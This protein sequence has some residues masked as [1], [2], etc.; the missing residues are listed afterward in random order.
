MPITEEVGIAWTREHDH[1]KIP[2]LSSVPRIVFPQS[3]LELIELVRDRSSGE[4]LKAAGS[5][6]ALSEAAVS[7]HTFVETHH[8]DEVNVAMGRTLTNVVP[9]CLNDDYVRRMVDMGSEGKWSLVHVEA[10]KRI[11]Q[12]YS[13]LDQVSDADDPETLA[14]HIKDRFQD[15]S[16]VGPWAFETLGGAGGQTVVGA[17]LTGT[18]GGDFD[19]PPLADS[20]L[21]MHLVSDGGRHYWV[22][23]ADPD[24]PPLTDDAMLTQE[25]GTEEFGG[26]DNFELIRD[27]DLFNSVLV[28][29]GRF[30]IVYSV[31]LKAVPQY[32]LYEKRRLHLWQDIKD[33]IVD[34]TSPLYTDQPPP[35]AE[36]PQRFLQVAVSLTTHLNFQRNLVGITKRWTMPT[37]PT[38]PGQ[39]ERVGDSQ[40]HDPLIQA[41]RFANAGRNHSYTPHPDHPERSAEP[42]M[43]EKACAD[44][45]FMRGVITQVINEIDDFVQ[46][47]GAVIGPAIAAVAA[48]GSG[49]LLLL[50][51][52][53]AALLLVLQDILDDIE[54]ATRFGQVMEAVKNRLLDPDNPDPASRAA[55]LF[56]WQMIYYLAF[57]Q[58]Q[59][60]RNYNALSYA[61]MDQK[62]YR[63]ISCEVNVESV[64]IFFNAVDRRLL[65][66]IDQLIVF[67]MGQE[68]AGKAF[69]GYASLRFTGPTRALLGMQRYPLTCSV[70]IACLKDVSGGQELI[71]F[72]VD[73]ASNPNIGGILH[74]GQFNPWTSTE[75][76]RTYGPS[77]NLATWRQA[78]A[79]IT[80]GGD[81]FSSEFTRRTGLEVI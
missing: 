23:P 2:H 63:N 73:W 4:R 8:P 6:W 28:S 66:F 51:G 21:A 16:F 65:A 75:V 49:G 3:L 20:V 37:S 53:F 35:G 25:F 19:R 33:Q 12:L 45:N 32:A 24:V 38:T 26:P 1:P 41:T 60:E 27:N 15:G 59:A 10:G 62:D 52:V 70:E 39:A 79:R 46:S 31:V 69:V 18:H 76:E 9:K 64:E 74:W 48:I 61:V 13:E 58:Q 81:K 5:H 47:N 55:G 14:G 34:P 43:L 29:A 56:T 54:D 44:A 30:G 71:N 80:G 72:A 77:G 17:F 42:G 50:L 36:G 40:G 67:E 57:E 7:D 78:L 22:E 68:L 11:Y